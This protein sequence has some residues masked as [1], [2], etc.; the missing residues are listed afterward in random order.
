M[1]KV[2][3]SIIVFNTDFVLRQCI[4][5]VYPY[6]SQILISEGCVGYWKDQGFT[7]STDQT[8][9]IINSFPD[10]DNKIKIVHG[11]YKEK[12]EQANAIIPYLKPDIDY[13]W[14]VDADEIFKP[15]DIEKIFELLDKEKYTSVGFKSITFY[16]GFNHYLT[17]FEEAHQFMRIRKVYPGSYWSDHRPPTIQHIVP[18]D[19]QLPEKHLSYN[20][21]AKM[22]IRMYHYSYVSPRQVF[23]KISYYE[24]AVI[25]KGSCIPDYFKSVFLEW[26]NSDIYARKSLENK[27]IGVHEFIPSYRGDCYTAKFTGE[28][29]D[30]IKRDLPELLNKFNEQLA[31]YTEI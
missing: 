12:T 22:D 2:A 18:T 14:N 10:P 6:A 7:T 1:P 28:H 16:G 5:S 30:V 23:E 8:N 9:E 26:I 31:R 11:T 20:V 13:L 4:E 17:G 15:Q 27:W 24:A 3:I 19:Q 29:P 25:K 21:L